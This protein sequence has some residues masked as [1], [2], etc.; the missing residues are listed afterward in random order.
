ML[1]GR[2]HGLALWRES[3]DLQAGSIWTGLEKVLE[4]LRGSKTVITREAYESCF[5][6]LF[7]H[8]PIGDWDCA[9]VGRK[10]YMVL[11]A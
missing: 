2:D 1:D 4:Q 9:M 6:T 11:H 7:G 10:I 3:L 5:L 8:T